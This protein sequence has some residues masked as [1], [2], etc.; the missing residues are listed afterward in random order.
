M[1]ISLTSSIADAFVVGTYG[2]ALSNIYAFMQRTFTFSSNN[3]YGFGFTTPTNII[4]DVAITT[5]SS[6]NTGF[7]C[8]NA[9]WVFFTI[10][11]GAAG[12]STTLG[13]ANITN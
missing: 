11:Q 2:L 5:S 3:I 10:Q 4:S 12:D 7:N 8:T 1:E 6:S 9:F 13:L